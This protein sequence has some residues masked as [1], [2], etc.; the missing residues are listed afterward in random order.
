MLVVINVLLYM[1]GLVRGFMLAVAADLAAMV[2]GGYLLGACQRARTGWLHFRAEVKEAGHARFLK[3][4]HDANHGADCFD[5]EFWHTK[6]F[7]FYASKGELL[8]YGAYLGWH[9]QQA[10]LG[11]RSVVDF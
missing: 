5:C 3:Y 6:Y 8:R 1:V 11:S 4:E 2:L 10:Y 9:N 7:Y